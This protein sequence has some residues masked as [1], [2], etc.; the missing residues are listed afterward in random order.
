VES[1]RARPR[2]SA[3]RWTALLTFNED[4]PK[5]YVHWAFLVLS[6]QRK[7]ID[8]PVRQNHLFFGPNPRDGHAAFGERWGIRLALSF[9]VHNCQAG[10]VNFDVTPANASHVVFELR[11][12]LVLFKET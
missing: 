10:I 2:C 9:F 1:K 6:F 5:T 3:G 4:P 11:R 12:I 8:V 7:F